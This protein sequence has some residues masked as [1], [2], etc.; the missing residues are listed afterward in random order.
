M[1][2]SCCS[3]NTLTHPSR[4]FLIAVASFLEREVVVDFSTVD[5]G[6]RQLK[7]EDS[8]WR[9]RERMKRMYL[10]TVQL[11][12]ILTELKWEGDQRSLEGGI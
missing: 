9:R 11:S 1:L 4:S 12:F 3:G 6:R 5:S 10:S 7:S 2:A 8:V